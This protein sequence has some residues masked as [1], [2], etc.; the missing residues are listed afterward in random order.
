ME[1]KG[2]LLSWQTSALRR[3]PFTFTYFILRSNK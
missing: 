3:N 2:S 1:I